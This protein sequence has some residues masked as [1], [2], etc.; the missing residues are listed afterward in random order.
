MTKIMLDEAINRFVNYCDIERRLSPNTIMAYR[1]DLRH[2]TGFA[3]NSQIE[4]ALTSRMLKSYL[5]QNIR[6]G[7]SSPATIRRRIVCLRLLCKYIGSHFEFPDPFVSWQPALPRPKRLP[8]HLT[9]S[10]VADLIVASSTNRAIDQ[11]TRSIILLLGATGIRVSEL[12][13]VRIQD[14]AKDGKSIRIR[15]KGAKERIV[16]IGNNQLQRDLIC[17]RERALEERTETHTLFINNRGNPL[18]PQ[19]VRKRFRNLCSRIPG[20]PHVTPHM[21]RHTAAT[22]LIEKGIDIR[23]VQRLLGHA[24]IST[25]EIYTHVSDSALSRAISKADTIE[26]FASI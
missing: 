2:F 11:E 25:T 26:R 24:S 14:L 9:D 21:L 16:F 10:D 20:S 8:R 13:G 17:R 5:A 23:I 12:C 1:A 19:V 3:S 7:K 6:T 18:K 4:F 15:G 22:L